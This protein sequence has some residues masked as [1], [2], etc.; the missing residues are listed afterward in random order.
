MGVPRLPPISSDFTRHSPL[1]TFLRPF[2]FILLQIPFL[3][4]PFVSHPYKTPGGVGGPSSLSRSVYA[5]KLDLTSN[6]QNSGRLPAIHHEDMAGDEIRSIGSQKDRCAFQ[7]VLVAEALQ[8]NLAQ[9]RLFVSLDHHLR[10]V[11]RKPAR[12]DGVHLNIMHA[13][14][15]RQVLGENDYAALAG[16]IPDGLKFRRRAAE[17]R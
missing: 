12:R 8:R 13:P 15:A 10:H 7:V 11:R 1:A 14:F 5:S 17:P 16:V 4:S 2:V 6:L 3:A 9:E